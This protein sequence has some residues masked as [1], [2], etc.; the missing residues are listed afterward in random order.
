MS[1]NIASVNAKRIGQDPAQLGSS[2]LLAIKSRQLENQYQRISREIS[3]YE[4][5]ARKTV[6]LALQY[7]LEIGKRLAHVKELMPHGKFLEWAHQEFGW[8]PRHVQNHLTLAANAKE[9]LRFPV[10]ASLRMVLAALRESHREPSKDPGSV[11]VLQPHQRIHLIGEIEEGTLDCEKLI[12]EVARIAAG[13][14]AT[15]TR[16]RAR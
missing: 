13:L 11:E 12:T 16:W 3:W 9:V 15:K 5:E 2:T 6:G 1:K 7:K 4:E 14:G 10:G 8:T